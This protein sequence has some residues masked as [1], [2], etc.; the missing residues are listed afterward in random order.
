MREDT[1]DWIA[2][3]VLVVFA[4]LS[5]CWATILTR[6]FALIGVLIGVL[7]TWAYKRLTK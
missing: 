2:V 6:G 7:L 1:K 3:T 4:V 5:V